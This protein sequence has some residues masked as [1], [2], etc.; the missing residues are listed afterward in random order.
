ML[1]VCR[2]FDS[3]AENHNS[4]FNFQKS[5]MIGIFYKIIK[6]LFYVFSSARKSMVSNARLK[7]N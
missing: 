3:L 6:K 5:L 7:L 2:V 1:N 4:V